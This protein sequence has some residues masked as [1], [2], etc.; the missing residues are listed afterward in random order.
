ML[1]KGALQDYRRPKI[2]DCG[3]VRRNV[4]QH[5]RS[6]QRAGSTDK[7]ERR[8][9]FPVLEDLGLASGLILPVCDS[10]MPDGDVIFDASK[11]HCKFPRC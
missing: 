11:V 7:R 9:L 2:W 5:G 10:T 1:K 4:I 8:T 3:G 6:A